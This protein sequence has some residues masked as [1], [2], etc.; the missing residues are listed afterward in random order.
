MGTSAGDYALFLGKRFRRV[1]VLPDIKG[2]SR[3]VVCA[4]D[5]DDAP[6]AAGERAGS[7]SGL[8][9]RE[10]L[11]ECVVASEEAWA[12]GAR[13]WEHARQRIQTAERPVSGHGQISDGAPTATDAAA[14]VLADVAPII[15]AS[16]ATNTAAPPSLTVTSASPASEKLA[17]FRS[18]FRGRGDVYAH[19]WWSAK[20]RR[21][22]FSPACGNEWVRGVCPLPRGRC[23]DCRNRLF[24]KLT[25]QTLLR[26]FTE[27]R[28]DLR[29]VVGIYPMD[30]DSRVWFLAIDFDKGDWRREVGYVR[31]VCEEHGVPCAVERSMSG[32]GA[33]L[34]MFF[35]E[36]VDAALARRFG[37]SLLTLAA[38]EHG[39]TTFATYDRL[40][41]NQ[42]VVPTGGFGN[43]IALPLQKR[44]RDQDNSV[45]VDGDF[46]PYADQWAYLSSLRR[47]GVE[48]M[49]E[50]IALNPGGPMGELLTVGDGSDAVASAA[51]ER[52]GA[53]ASRLSSA[54]EPSS[55][56]MTLVPTAAS[57][58]S[59]RGRTV[60]T[61][62]SDMPSIVHVTR[63]NLL[64][65]STQGM[66]PAARNAIRRLAAFANPE[67][68][69][70]QTMRQPVYGKTRVIDLGG[71]ADGTI[72]L[73]RGC[74]EPLEAV[75]HAAGARIDY[76]DRRSP[77]RTIDVSFR[78]ELR[79]RQQEAVDAMLA[80]DDGILVAPTGFGKTVT[81]AAL[82]ARRR[83]STLIILRSA[84][85]MEQWRS[86][87][88][89]F[90]DVR[91]QVPVRRT[92]TGR[93]A[94]RQPQVIGL[95]GD[96]HDERSGIIDIALAPSLVGK[97][98]ISGTKT[99][100]PWVGDYGM[101]VF[102]ECHHVAAAGQEAIA[103]VVTAR[104]V[105]GLTGTPKREDGLHPIMLMQCGP[106]RHTVDVREQMA[107][108][109]FRRILVPR[110]TT[111]RV[112]LD[113]SATYND[114]LAAACASEARNQRIVRDAAEAVGR[115]RTPVVL[116][117]RVGH[118][119]E[120]ARMLEECGCGRVVTLTGRGSAR[121]RQ[122][123]LDGLKA[124]PAGERFVTVAT[125]AYVGE[126]F[127][128]PRWDTLLLAAPISWEGPVAQAVGRLHRDAEGKSEAVVYDYAD[129]GVAM[130]ERIYR[131]R[132]KAYAKLGYELGK[133]EGFRPLAGAPV[134][135][136]SAGSG[137]AGED[138][139]D[140]V[141]TDGAAGRG[142]GG[143]SV[144]GAAK[145]MV[146]ADE[147]DALL[148]DD[149]TACRETLRLSASFLSVGGVRRVE[150]ALKDAIGRGVAVDVDV[151][152]P[153][154]T[155]GSAGLMGSAESAEMQRS[156]LE[157]VVAR[158]RD[159]G[160]RVREVAWCAD[161]AVFDG[162]LV[163]Y[164]GIPL[165]GIGRSAAD[166]CSLR[167]LDPDLARILI[168]NQLQGTRPLLG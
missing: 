165:L 85:L 10:A 141:G 12:A 164:G 162:R 166:E 168:G 139:L 83:V 138:G 36:Q 61:V 62:P 89:S 155:A 118:A 47:V 49:R 148:R 144:G 126:G 149:I 8:P 128:C 147:A 81:A 116:T 134:A 95:I 107:T 143:Y 39:L 5:A 74:R 133:G 72:L 54:A 90:L 135:A 132:L 115:G 7:L 14:K 131:K 28:A 21:K 151:R 160:C 48:R 50:V 150:R 9:L 34:W 127:D 91:E 154:G 103:R 63:T 84:A 52:R 29:N 35:A 106:I 77:G 79:P 111:L 108:Q 80:H 122:E 142:V 15:G 104:Y 57:S 53:S 156:R 22:G 45:F 73:P 153:V 55:H 109:R 13:A 129:I 100:K 25:D 58:S 26:H 92:A 158:L 161:F 20:L 33:H 124:M 66:S 68:A 65:I 167:V 6:D 136:G 140:G 51:S 78:G 98:D 130:L 42:G 88:A 16:A 70:A 18:L 71:E 59:D 94:K 157:R 120:L 44:A 159:L 113:R 41:P 38:K 32:N 69:R 60:L 31:Q 112:E 146:L 43:L 19:G 117:K 24:L 99:V 152:M 37:D 17:L 123:R 145:S 105:V 125:T 40:F 11:E 46:Q 97:G 27:D 3:V 121:E 67:F 4:P 2:T 114:Y 102:D 87:L 75:V 96:G 119:E 1:G 110:F 163:W 64:E 93:L 137:G 30:A 101:V 82:I 23:G 86:A 56:V 76:A